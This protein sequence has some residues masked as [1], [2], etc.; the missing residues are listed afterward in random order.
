MTEM[1]NDNMHINK[2]QMTFN[3]CP[4][5]S[6]MLKDNTVYK[7]STQKRGVTITKQCIHIRK[8]AENWQGYAYLHGHVNNTC[9]IFVYILN[10][11]NINPKFIVQR[12]YLLITSVLVS[13]QNLEMN[14]IKFSTAFTLSFTFSFLTIHISLFYIH[15]TLLLD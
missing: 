8:S 9:I 13:E 10:T 15:L 11:N 7:Y 12:S 4:I 5:F 2:Y 14:E 3:H 6:V 1:T